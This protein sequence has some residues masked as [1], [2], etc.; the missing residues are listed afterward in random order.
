MTENG[1]EDNVYTLKGQHDPLDR[2]FQQ[3]GSEAN[4]G[5]KQ[6]QTFHVDAIQMT[7]LEKLAKEHFKTCRRANDRALLFTHPFEFR[8]HADSVSTEV[9]AVCKS[10][11]KRFDLSY[12]DDGNLLQSEY[13]DLLNEPGPPIEIALGEYV[14]DYDESISSKLKRIERLRLILGDPESAFDIE[15]PDHRKGT[16]RFTATAVRFRRRLSRDELLKWCSERSAEVATPKEGLDVLMV[17]KSPIVDNLGPCVLAGQL[18][19]QGFFPS[20]V[21]FIPRYGECHV[22]IRPVPGGGSRVWEWF[23]VLKKV[24]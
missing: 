9:H 4:H 22:F 10:C 23:I 11:R 1:T 16:Q 2:A 12:D 20:V 5:W 8:F 15:F 13:M 14:I 24:P 3:L 7:V 6:P 18:N 17:L 19:T 21:Y